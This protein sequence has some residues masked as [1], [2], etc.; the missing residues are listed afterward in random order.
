MEDLHAFIC[1]IKTKK[2]PTIET[3][4]KSEIRKASHCLKEK[5]TKIGQIKEV[6]R[7]I[8]LQRCNAFNIF[9]Y[10]HELSGSSYTVIF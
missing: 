5:N 7:N 9:Q 1:M 3:T 10:A 8:L 6:S 2:A 4:E